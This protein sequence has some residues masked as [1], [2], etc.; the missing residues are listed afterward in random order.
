MKI[1]MVG[2]GSIGARHLRNLPD[3]LSTRKTEFQI[4][5]FRSNNRELPEDV[6]RLLI[7]QYF[8]E[9]E[10]PNDYDVAFICTPTSEHFKT[11]RMMIPRA[12]H[13]F[14]EKPVFVNCSEGSSL[15]LQTGQIY[16][17]A[18]PMRYSKLLITLRNMLH[19]KKVFSARIISSTY[20]PAWRPNTDYRKIYSA[21]AKMGGGIELDMIHEWD[22]VCWLFGFPQEVSVYIGKVSDLEIDSND[23]AVYIGKYQDKL[24]SVYLDYF[25]NPWKREIELHTSDG[26]IVTDLIQQQIRMLKNGTVL[27]CTEDRDAMQKRELSCFFDMIDGKCEN[28]NSVETAIKML[29]IAKGEY[30]P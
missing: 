9:A 14:I 10:L 29:S 22:Y 27:D 16:Y 15:S 24:V 12:K 13:L 1:C 26:T 7:K 19:E 23:I 5:A 30:R 8:H 4:D 17:V 25:G 18:C 28:T 3:V 2:L 6:K 11:I 20:L 21:S